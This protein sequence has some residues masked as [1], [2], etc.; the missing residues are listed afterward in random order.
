MVRILERVLIIWVYLLKMPIDFI[1]LPAL[2]DNGKT[3][4]IP[5]C[6]IICMHLHYCVL[7]GPCH[8]YQNCIILIDGHMHE[9]LWQTSIKLFNK[10][11]VFRFSIFVGHYLKFMKI[12]PSSF[13]LLGLLVH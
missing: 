8:I 6:L 5:I 10:T 3:G 1:Q 7:S 4:K 13:I 12:D 9:V 11:N 2:E